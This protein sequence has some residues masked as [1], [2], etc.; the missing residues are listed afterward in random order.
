M[1]RIELS[2]HTD[3]SGLFRAQDERSGHPAFPG[4]P[5]LLAAVTHWNGGLDPLAVSTLWDDLGLGHHG[6]FHAR[7]WPKARRTELDKA[8]EAAVRVIASA[9]GA[10][11]EVVA[12]RFHPRQPLPREDVYLDLVFHL[13]A[14]AVRGAVRAVVA[15]ESWTG[16]VP[17]KVELNLARRDG[18]NLRP[19]E[20]ALERMIARD[21]RWSGLAKAHGKRKG[22][23]LER[24][25]RESAISVH[26]SVIPAQQSVYLT[27]SDLLC[28]ALFRGLSQKQDA[29]I[30][31][32]RRIEHEELDKLLDGPTW[33]AVM[34]DDPMGPAS[35]APSEAA[36]QPASSAQDRLR[37]YL[38]PQSLPWTIGGLKAAGI[39]AQACPLDERVALIQGLIE[40]AEVA[41]EERRELDQAAALAVLAASLLDEREWR[42]GLDGDEHARL[43]LD[44]DSVR[45]AVANHRGLPLPSWFEEAA[46]R[47]RSGRLI[48][49][50]AHHDAVAL[51]HNRAAVNALNRFAFGEAADGAQALVGLLRSERGGYQDLFGG[52][53]PPSWQYGALLGTLGQALALH[54]HS[55]ADSARVE[56][57]IECFIE[58]GHQF[59]APADKLRQCS[60]LAHAYLDLVRLAGDKALPAAWLDMLGMFGAELDEDVAGFCAAPTGPAAW[61]QA[62]GVHVRLKEAWIL[63]ETPEWAAGLARS[64]RT[65]LS[66]GPLTHPM[67]QV[68]GLLALLLDLPSSDPLVAA[69][70]ATAD[71][72][73]SLVNVIARTYAL[74]L[75]AR[76]RAVTAETLSRFDAALPDWLRAGWQAQGIPD[77][78]ARARA[79]DTPFVEALPFYYF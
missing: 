47:Q 44:G 23:F 15:D 17:L 70:Q 36:A 19:L 77:A 46:V 3:E 48:A 39:W 9:R 27:V 14:G 4:E 69:V 59:D 2:I 28:N 64:L 58:A 71:A 11:L 51:L 60:Y 55:S 35:R 52:S 72:G 62:F 25:V 45:L 73:S 79:Q 29:A 57:A 21:L 37:A 5:F 63:G 13:V 1:D 41:C 42:K 67:Q 12:Y 30:R 8:A 65:G 31:L 24:G 75:R 33:A 50:A 61:R 68:C 6:L 76:F 22:R 18:L 26:C 32:T 66:P 54:G 34:A 56:R 49:S 20:G 40:D 7:D 53:A 10:G 74:D 16:L 38:T 78:L 43:S